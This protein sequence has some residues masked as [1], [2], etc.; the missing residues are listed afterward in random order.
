MVNSVKTCTLALPSYSFI[1]LA[2]TESENIGLSVSEIVEVFVNTL[3]A[4]DKYSLRDRK[5]LPLPI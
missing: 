2:E 4:D 1:T 3:A 5:N